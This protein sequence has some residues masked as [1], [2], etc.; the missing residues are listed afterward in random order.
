MP[1]K[2]S[3]A[4]IF[5]EWW[6][7]WRSPSE[8][9][10]SSLTVHLSR[11]NSTVCS[12]IMWIMGGKISTLFPSTELVYF[13]GLCFLSSLIKMMLYGSLQLF[14]W[15]VAHIIGSNKRKEV[16]CGKRMG[17]LVGGS[18]WDSSSLS[19][20]SQGIDKRRM[21]RM[22]TLLETN[23]SRP[24]S[25]SPLSVLSVS[26]PLSLLLALFLSRVLRSY[27]KFSVAQK[28]LQVEHYFQ[29]SRLDHCNMLYLEF[30]WKTSQK[31]QIIQ[32]A[33]VGD[34]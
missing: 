5:H 26:L 20:I 16:E 22:N 32:S 1:I 8:Q 13:H 21:N 29:H 4:V 6:L 18:D 25:L 19:L 24:P 15:A 12:F 31:S 2:H 30:P 34:C 9:P 7:Y 27:S 28:L 14:P 23:S 3:A 17:P 33:A 10:S 11:R